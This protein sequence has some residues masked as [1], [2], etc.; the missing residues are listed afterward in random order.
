ME[1]EVFGGKEEMPD[2]PV[3]VAM[4]VVRGGNGGRSGTPG[5]SYDGYGPAQPGAPGRPGPTKKHPHGDP[6]AEPGQ[7]PLSPGNVNP[8][9][10]I[11]EPEGRRLAPRKRT[12]K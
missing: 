1:V 3:V 2:T 6:E 10:P 12:G 9:A 7:G 11:S 5:G 8:K 4:E